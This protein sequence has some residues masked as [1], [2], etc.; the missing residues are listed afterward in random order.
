VVI[1]G[2]YVNYHKSCISPDVIHFLHTLYE[3]VAYSLNT[4]IF[5]IAGLKMGTLIVDESLEIALPPNGRTATIFIGIFACLV[6]RGVSMA[7]F[8]PLLQRFGT[9]C[10]WQEAVVMW[11]GG[12]RGSVGLALALVV[13]HSTYD[14]VMWG[15][16]EDAG[17]GLPCRDYPQGILLV[18]IGVICF[19]VVFN[20]MTMRGLM[21]WL[22]LTEPSDE[23]NFMVNGAFEKMRHDARS[24]FEKQKNERPQVFSDIAFEDIAKWQV[25]D[26]RPEWKKE[27]E[28]EPK[29]A[30][31]EVLNIERSSYLLQFERGVLG[32][33]AFN[34]LETFMSSLNAEASEVGAESEGGEDPLARFSSLKAV[35]RRTNTSTGP[36]GDG[37]APGGSRA[38]GSTGTDDL[39]RARKHKSIEA[40]E[41]LFKFYEA[42]IHKNEMRRK[43][44]LTRGVTGRFFTGS[45]SRMQVDHDDGTADGAVSG[46]P[47]AAGAAPAESTMLQNEQSSKSG[48]RSFA[49]QL[50]DMYD[51]HFNELVHELMSKTRPWQ[52]QL[53]YEVGLAYLDAF[54][55]VKHLTHGK[56]VFEMIAHE[57]E[58]NTALMIRGMSLIQRRMPGLIYEFKKQY[59]ASQ[60]LHH[61]QHLVEHMRHEGELLDLDA[62]PIQV[63]GGYLDCLLTLTLTPTP[64]F[65]PRTPNR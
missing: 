33:E 26:E 35:L 12:L 55:E 6:A 24:F 39:L 20:G 60:L 52:L 31:L 10:T 65:L 42:E 54:S 61:Q 22:R 7:L 40:L 25:V 44:T 34:K 58:D 57:H 50:S 28:D 9:G 19:T 41:K 1:M 45:N 48:R 11:W 5:A 30:W 16:H 2:L 46:E 49:Q 27:V 53:A 29:A 64:K 18:T 37:S 14:A 56:G 32:S 17:G 38:D 13:Y 43:R 36:G 23:R 47:G 8:F 51:C 62:N 15:D 3:F 21:T 59:C 63:L 4:L